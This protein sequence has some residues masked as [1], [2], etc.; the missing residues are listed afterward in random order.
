[1][2]WVCD[3]NG[4]VEGKILAR[5]HDVSEVF[6]LKCKGFRCQFSYDEENVCQEPFSNQA[7][8]DDLEYSLHAS[9]NQININEQQELI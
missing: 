1:M 4:V 3:F 9:I 6:L 7:C 2:F 5:Y 8:T